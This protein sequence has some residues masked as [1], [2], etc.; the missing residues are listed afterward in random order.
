[1][2]SR[3]NIVIVHSALILLFC[4]L[5]GIGTF[6]DRDISGALYSPM[7]TL[8]QIVTSTGMYVPF[9]SFV[10]FEAVLFGQYSV[11][12][13]IT[14]KRRTI[15]LCVTGGF[16]FS[17]GLAGA[18]TLTHYESLGAFDVIE[19]I[20]QAVTVTALMAVT[21][22]PVFL[23]GR[24]CGRRGYDERLVRRLIRLM[25]FISIVTLLMISGKT[26]FAR[27]RYRTTLEPG[28]DFVPW[29][30]LALSS[31]RAARE[32]GLDKNAFQSFPSGH[33]ISNV[34]GIFIFPAF[35]WVLPKLKGRETVLFLTGL[36][37]G[38]VIMLTRLILGAH[39][40]TD[41]SFG[42]LIAVIIGFVYSMT[43]NRK[44]SAQNDA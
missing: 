41:V 9:A 14:R 38:L 6:Y 13:G 8:V 23:W 37:Y 44:G 15:C 27:P 19:R 2:T 43:D 18:I 36:I 42:A 28:I 7:N 11:Q 24:N 40:L 39:F 3:R 32:T 35:S 12:P 29:Y 31:E 5:I 22:L 30:D 4:T 1:M 26:V 34:A 16:A 25:I 21:M 20:P 33:S 10:F 17:V